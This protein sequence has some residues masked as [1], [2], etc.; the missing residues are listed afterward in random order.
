LAAVSS[1]LADLDSQFEALEAAMD[2]EI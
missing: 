2:H 1:Q